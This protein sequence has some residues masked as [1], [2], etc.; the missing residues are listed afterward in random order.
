MNAWLGRVGWI[1]ATGCMFWLVSQTRA[2]VH[3]QSSDGKAPDDGR[4]QVISTLL[5]SGVQQLAIVDTRSR[6]LAV[7]H[8]EPTA[9]K[10]QLR[11]VRNMLWDL[12]M[13]H[14]NGQSP[15]PSELRQVQP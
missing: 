15:L 5:P 9:G 6:S 13:E 4:L 7:Y 11:S 1:A 3:S 12:Q 10:V 8:I 14:F 2:T